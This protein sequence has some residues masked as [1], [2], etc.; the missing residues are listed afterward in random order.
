[1]IYFGENA[2]KVNERVIELTF[3]INSD[4]SV[5][6]SKVTKIDD[7]DTKD[8]NRGLVAMFYAR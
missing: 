5:S 3:T 7:G 1:M 2:R 4:K 8:I 6:I